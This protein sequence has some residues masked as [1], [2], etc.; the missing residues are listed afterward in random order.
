[1][2]FF[3]CFFFFLSEYFLERYAYCQIIIL[4]RLF[5]L[6]LVVVEGGLQFTIPI[7]S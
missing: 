1:M 7:V 6:E 3:L 5:K 2:P 4:Y